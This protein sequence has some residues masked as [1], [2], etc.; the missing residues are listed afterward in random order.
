[1]KLRRGCYCLAAAVLGAVVLIALKW[2]CCG[3]PPAQWS[4]GAWT[5]A[6][7]IVALFGI[8]GA[9]SCAVPRPPEDES[10]SRQGDMS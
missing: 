2:G 6:I 4:A 8:G 5:A 1:M 9:V 10:G 7:L 3:Y